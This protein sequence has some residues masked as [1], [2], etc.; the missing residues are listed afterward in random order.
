MFGEIG[1]I[2]RACGWRLVLFC[3]SIFFACICLALMG[4]YQ[5]MRTRLQDEFKDS[6]LRLSILLNTVRS[7]AYVFSTTRIYGRTKTTP[8]FMVYHLPAPFD[9]LSAYSDCLAFARSF[10]YGS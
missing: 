1:R 5:I 2:E 7:Q 3:D 10:A 4:I 8:R 6:W 9:S